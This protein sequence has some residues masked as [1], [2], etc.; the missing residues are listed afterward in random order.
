MKLTRFNHVFMVT[1]IIFASVLPLLASN[2]PAFSSNDQD[3]SL[4]FDKNEVVEVKYSPLGEILKETVWVEFEVYNNG[5][6]PANCY[7][8]DRI[9]CINLDSLTMLYGTPDPT[10]IE[11]FG[12]ITIITWSNVTIEADSSVEY[13]YIAE[14]WRSVP[15]A[16]NETIYVNGN[17]TTLNHIGNT[18]TLNASVSD[19]VTIQT[20]ITNIG[21]PLYTDMNTVI[22]EIPCTIVASLSDEYFSDITTTPEANSTSSISDMSTITWIITLNDSV[23]LDLSAEIE[24]VSSWGEA[25]V[26]SFIIQVGSIPESTAERLEELIENLEDAIKALQRQRDAI[27]NMP[28]FLKRIFQGSLDDVTEQIGELNDEKLDLKEQL[29]IIQNQKKPYNV[30]AYSIED[31]QPD[32]QIDVYTVKYK[33]ANS[34]RNEE[35]A[36]E[37]I[38][39]TNMGNSTLVINGL[40]LQISSNGSVLEPKYASVLV[41]PDKRFVN[42]QWQEFK[43]D[44]TKVGI[45][46]D[47]MLGTLYLE[48]KIVVNASESVNV[49]V[50]W[51]E[52]SIKIIFE[53]DGPPEVNYLVDVEKRY[54]DVQ[55][56]PSE[57]TVTCFVKQPNV[58][59]KELT[60]PEDPPPG[61]GL[62]PG[63]RLG[64][65]WSII[66]V[67]CV[68]AIG[69]YILWRRRKKVTSV[70]KV[71][72]MKKITSVESVETKALLDKIGHLKKTL[73][74]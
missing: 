13:Q 66:G 50:D 33:W 62:P 53:C 25:S 14:T 68:V 39:I 63:D 38:E 41:N 15:V 64:F 58:F 43:G 42:D 72:S 47:A 56:E 67:I 3:H 2:I 70:K 61:D 23:T 69:G 21:Q 52:R 31:T 51:A 57:S 26:E 10:N 11:T 8:K 55:V 74:E 44:L 29:L 48:P 6:S 40:A 17:Q 16:I 28:G 12:N 34:F 37:S 71:S 73:K 9:K 27:N 65:V 20:T 24:A 5:S 59:Y 22:P 4:L 60:F 46:Y 35:W 7:I 45:A 36:V 32:Y 18:Y 19:T 54:P 49:L 30:E 1:L